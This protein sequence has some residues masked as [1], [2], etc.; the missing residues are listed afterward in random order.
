MC[1]RF[2]L[3][4]RARLGRSRRSADFGRVDNARRPSQL[5]FRTAPLAQPFAYGP[6]R[7]TRRLRQA[8]S[9]SDPAR[10]HLRYRNPLATL[11]AVLVRLLRQSRRELPR[12]HTSCRRWHLYRPFAVAPSFY[13]AWSALPF[14]EVFASGRVSSGSGSLVRPSHFFGRPTH[15]RRLWHHF[16]FRRD[17]FLRL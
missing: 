4:C 13:M 15:S 14:D 2:L 6:A 17:D 10:D 7:D 9:H 12:A 11:A 8:Q 16:D 5:H 3:S 1:P